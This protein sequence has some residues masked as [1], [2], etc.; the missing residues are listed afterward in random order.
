MDLQ[1]G[2]WAEG[3]DMDTPQPTPDTSQL[4][5]PQT[6]QD[7]I[8]TMF[9]GFGQWVQGTNQLQAAIS[10]ML[11]ALTAQ[12][13]AL[14]AQTTTIQ[15][16]VASPPAAA[17]NPDMGEFTSDGNVAMQEEEDNNEDDE[18]EGDEMDV[19][20]ELDGGTNH[21]LHVGQV[22]QGG[23]SNHQCKIPRGEMDND[24]FSFASFQKPQRP[25]KPRTP[26]WDRRAAFRATPYPTQPP[27]MISSV[28]P[29]SAYS[30]PVSCLKHTGT[31]MSQSS[32]PSSTKG[33]STTLDQFKS[34]IKDQLDEVNKDTQ[35]VK[36]SAS[37]LKNEWYHAKMNFHMR[38]REILHLEAE[39]TQAHA[40]AEEMHQH[41][42]E[43]KKD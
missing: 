14:S 32:L 12:L 40:E 41:E 37:M 26:F 35:D 5:N 38:E 18:G 39:H 11:Q 7:A 25:L 33:K 17:L 16:S 43:M 3:L 13:T 19:D 31:P 30:D 4:E 6:W 23:S 36:V 29:P 27:S 20:K 8:V 1:Q 42:L 15:Q 22:A 24:M 2:A 28:T 21:G 34:S 9:N 10:G